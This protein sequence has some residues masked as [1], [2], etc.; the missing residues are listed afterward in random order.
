MY[1]TARMKSSTAQLSHGAVRGWRGFVQRFSRRLTDRR[2]WVVQGLILIATGIHLSFDGLEA[3]KG[4]RS[5]DLFVVLMYAILFVPVIY[6]SLSFGR[7][8]AI[9]TAI[10]LATLALPSI[11]FFHHGLD[12]VAET[13]Q[14]LTIISLA[15]FIASRVDREIDARSQAEAEAQARRM[16]EAMY[17][18]LFESAGEAILVV[19]G[20]GE[21]LQANDLSSQLFDR[22]IAGARGTKLADLIGAPNATHLLEVGQNGEVFSQDISIQTGFGREFW[23]E[24]VCSVVEN[25]AGQE[26]IQI[27]MRDVTERRARQLGLE[28]YARRITQA[29]E[30]ERRRIARELH[31]SS[32]QSV[33]LLCR[34]LDLLE[35]SPDLTDEVRRALAAS[36]ESAETIADEL[37]RFSRDLRPS[38]LDDLGLV[39]ALRWLARDLEDRTGVRVNLS[40]DSSIARLSADVELGVFRM[41]QEALHNVERHAEACTVDISLSHDERQLTLTVADDGCGMSIDEAMANS[42]RGDKL[43]LLGM[44]ERARLLDGTVQVA[45]AHRSG[46]RIEINVPIADRPS[47]G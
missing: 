41:C 25:A 20:T 43:G 38:I 3:Y 24:P 46:T 30:E 19:A 42:I 27:L 15:V 13:V 6:A 33:V 5:P 17:R 37:R 34:R 16:S 44:Q 29:Q 36:R 26:V 35:Q 9:P 11:I 10:W 1:E 40:A 23:V 2:F 39:P 14:H 4:V 8:G 31:D 7:E 28:T 12:R 45:S 22:P 21:V 32:L 47:Q 18:G